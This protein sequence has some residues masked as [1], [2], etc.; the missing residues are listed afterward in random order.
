ME[1]LRVCKDLFFLPF[2]WM[3]IVQEQSFLWRLGTPEVPRPP[4]STLF[5]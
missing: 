4:A 3:C 1:D 5:M 2:S